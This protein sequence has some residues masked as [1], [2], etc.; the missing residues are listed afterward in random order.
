MLPLARRVHPGMFAGANQNARDL[1]Q[2]SVEF[3]WLK[4]HGGDSRVIDS[5]MRSYLIW[6]EWSW[7]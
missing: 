4:R 2:F 7:G 5:W 1:V 6:K 3:Q